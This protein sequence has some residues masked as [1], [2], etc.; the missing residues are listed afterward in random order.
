VRFFVLR[1]GL[2]STL[3]AEAA[4][5]PIMSGARMPEQAR[6]RQK[7][8]A[9]LTYAGQAAGGRSAICEGSTSGMEESRVNSHGT[10]G[11]RRVASSRLGR[12]RLREACRARRS[13]RLLSAV[14]AAVA[15]L[16]TTAL[17]LSAPS[18]G[19]I[20]NGTSLPAQPWSAYITLATALDTEQGNVP[21]TCTGVLIAAYMVLTADHC[22]HADESPTGAVFAADDL[23]VIMGRN[24]FQ[25]K[26]GGVQF[27][28]SEVIP[29]PSWNGSAN[30]DLALL[31]LNAGSAAPPTAWAPMPLAPVGY[32]LAAGAPMTDWGYGWDAVQF[33]GY[34]STT[35]WAPVKG[36]QVYPTELQETQPGSYVVGGGCGDNKVVACF[37]DQ[38]PSHVLYGDSGSPWS[39]TATSPFV[40][41][42]LHGWPDLFHWTS[43]TTGYFPYTEGADVS[44]PPFHN[45][46][47]DNAGIPSY[48]TGTILR[49][50]ITAQAWLVEGDGFLHPIA[51]GGTYECLVGQGSVVDNE[52]QF[53]IDETPLSTSDATCAP[54]QTSTSLGTTTPTTAFQPTTPPPTSSPSESISVSWGSNAAPSGNWMDITFTGFPTG[55]VT[56]YC[57]EEGTSYGPYS[58]TLTSSTETL[59]TDTCYDTEAGGSDYVTAD[60]VNSNTIGTD[61]VAAPPPPPPPPPSQSISIAWGSNAAPAGKWMDITFTNFPTGLVS[62]VC[63]EE[64]HGYGPYS[65]TL[66]SSTETLTSH[67]CYDTEGGGTDYVTADGVSSNTIGTD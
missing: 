6:P 7:A 53:L 65:T 14:T 10:G 26:T 41:A 28:V 40:A 57:V 36:T 46:I 52:T 3:E 2:A 64:G 19:A 24:D 4:G 44:N 32:S 63:V 37:T 60:G 16:S 31:V 51:D 22:V 5:S 35:N 27:G 18:A 9:R 42:I 59:T 29:Y 49:N 25:A 34:P 54:P 55:A 66:T 39:P 23:H 45:W 21:E 56:W 17:F 50:L 1:S 62:W 11:R 61:S 8:A 58:T 38:G 30:G 47:V 43:R 67:T 48:S 20:A 12:G 33:K 15:L 13:W